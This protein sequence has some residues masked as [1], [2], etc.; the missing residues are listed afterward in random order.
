MND[1]SEGAKLEHRITDDSRENNAGANLIREHADYWKPS[2]ISLNLNPNG[3]QKSDFSCTDLEIIPMQNARH[4]IELKSEK[5]IETSQAARAS[6]GH[7]QRSSQFIKPSNGS[8]QSYKEWHLCSDH[9]ISGLI[10]YADAFVVESADSRLPNTSHGS[11]TNQT[12]WPASSMLPLGLSARIPGPVAAV[13]PNIRSPLT[14]G[15]S[16]ATLL[17]YCPSRAPPTVCRSEASSPADKSDGSRVHA[18]GS[19]EPSGV[20]SPSRNIRRAAALRPFLPSYAAAAALGPLVADV[21]AAAAAGPPQPSFAAVAA[22]SPYRPAETVVSVWPAAPHSLCAGRP[23]GSG[24]PA[25]R[26]QDPAAAP[27]MSPQ[28]AVERQ[29][30]ASVRSAQYAA[31]LETGSAALSESGHSGHESGAPFAPSALPENHSPRRSIERQRGPGALPGADPG[32]HGQPTRTRLG[33]DSDHGD[34]VGR[35]WPARAEV[36]A[37]DHLASAAPWSAFHGAGRKAGKRP[38]AAAA[39]AAGAVHSAATMPGRAGKRLA[40]GSESEGPLQPTTRGHVRDTPP[41][42]SMDSDLPA[43][44]EAGARAPSIGRSSGLY[45]LRRLSSESPHDLPGP[46]APGPGPSVGRQPPAADGGVGGDSGAG[47]AESDPFH[48]D[49]PFW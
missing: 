2:N 41:A 48:D 21:R 36:A 28:R 34:A 9:T 39:S 18:S 42:G 13:D 46:A 1:C 31:V 45:C 11:A 38:A 47:P 6:S 27:A 40:G 37:G 24:P 35:P 32:C 29:A 10:S 16:P 3:E 30:A 12:F 26:I 8:F 15:T 7:R 4:L 23:G 5:Q 20:G 22:C 19:E 14:L 43:D 33:R 25:S 44:S 17:G 49:Y